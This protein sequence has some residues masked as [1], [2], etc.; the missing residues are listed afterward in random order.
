VA[1]KIGRNHNLNAN[2]GSIGPS[3]TFYL[4]YQE[5]S[6]LSL[7][8]YRGC[9][10]VRP[11]LDLDAALGVRDWSA[12]RTF[13]CRTRSANE[14]GWIATSACSIPS[15]LL[16]EMVVK[17]AF[18]T[19]RDRATETASLPSDSEC[20]RVHG[21]KDQTQR[22]VSREH[23]LLRPLLSTM[24]SAQHLHLVLRSKNFVDCSKMEC[25]EGKL[26]CARN[27]T[28]TPE[29]REVLQR[30]DGSTT[31]RAARRA[32]SGRSCAM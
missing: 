25:R 18:P 29:T 14:S 27:A 3:E 1:T 20:F 2:R 19:R 10:S 24:E 15:C 12:S 28:G 6:P 4:A 31:D 17:D 21:F 11:I 8:G 7:A 22:R 26:S 9:P 30:A 23:S 5:P 13:V 32:A 16:Q